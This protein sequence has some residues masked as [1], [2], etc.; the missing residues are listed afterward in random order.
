MTI[1]T[2]PAPFHRKTRVLV[3]AVALITAMGVGLGQQRGVW[4][5]SSDRGSTSPPAV[6][7]SIPSVSGVPSPQA[8]QLYVVATEEAEVDL[9]AKFE[10]LGHTDQ[11]YEVL[12]LAPAEDHGRVFARLYERNQLRAFNGVLPVSINDLR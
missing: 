3:A 11:P 10:A 1:I 9:R 2:R 5:D 6:A 12:V 4:T 8:P 7:A